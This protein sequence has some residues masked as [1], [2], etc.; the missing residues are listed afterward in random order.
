[1]DKRS[2]KVESVM[3]SRGCPTKFNNDSRYISKT[4]MNAAK[5]AYTYL[6]NR[7]NIRGPCTLVITVLETTRSSNKK[8]V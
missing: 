7:E 5:K 6:C 3:T 2:F 8:T 1:M 4:P